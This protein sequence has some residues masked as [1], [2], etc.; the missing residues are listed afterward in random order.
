MPQIQYPPTPLPDVPLEN[1]FHVLDESG[2]KCGNAA[3]IEYVNHAVLPERPLNYYISIN[4]AS[5]RAFDMLIGAALA[6]S[7]ELRLR[8]PSL[9]AR[10][11]APCKPHDTESLRNLQSF[12]FQNDDAIIRMRRILS[13]SERVPNPPV[14][15]AVAPVLL[16][17]SEDC[18]G[19]LR[20]VNAYSITAQSADWLARLRQEQLFFVFGVWQEQRLLGEMILTAYGVEGRV[21]MIYTRP[22]YRR[23]GV[24]TSLLAHAG[25]VLLQNGLRSLNAEVWRRNQPAMSLFQAS[26]FESIS[27]TMLYPGIDL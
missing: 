10:I 19:L 25:Q 17:D 23:R 20:R 7:M 21:E 22:E 15:C 4:A 3:V 6:R 5:E 16:E 2:M 24:A 14:G 12:G 11:Y 8:N 9:P 26:R 18:E 1:T 27:P 13:G